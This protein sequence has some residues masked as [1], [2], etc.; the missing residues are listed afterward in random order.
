MR[1]SASTVDS[2]LRPNS[3]WH[4]HL[5]ANDHGD[6]RLWEVA[7]LFHLRDAFRSGDIW[8]DHSRRYGNLKQV[9]V[10]MIAAQAS[11]RLTVPLDPQAWLTDRKARLADGLKR[12]A[13]AARSRTAA[14]R[15]EHCGSTE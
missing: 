6:N 12:L 15:M 10:P 11:T 5:R 13:R 7:V 2:F 9:L 4:R 8:L 1:V 14:S 3:K